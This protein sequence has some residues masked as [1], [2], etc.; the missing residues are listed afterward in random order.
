V[1][2][3]YANYIS[4]KGEGIIERKVAVYRSD[5]HLLWEKGGLFFGPRLMAL[6]PT[7]SSVIVS[8]GEHSI[9]NLD[10]RGKILSKFD[11]AGGIRKAVSSEDGRRIL[12]H[13][14]DGWL[15]LMGVGQ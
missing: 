9:Y 10:R 1:A 6:S 15:Y 14:G 13:C 7:G 3:S 4:R 2:V 12:L 8:D 5:G 11:M